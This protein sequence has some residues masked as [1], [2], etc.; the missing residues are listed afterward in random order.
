MP[1]VAQLGRET[2]ASA[3]VCAASLQLDSELRRQVIGTKKRVNL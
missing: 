3:T 2:Q 1:A